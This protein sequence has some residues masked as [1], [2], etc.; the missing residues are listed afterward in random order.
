LGD[1]AARARLRPGEKKMSL[2]GRRWP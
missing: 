1:E 2:S